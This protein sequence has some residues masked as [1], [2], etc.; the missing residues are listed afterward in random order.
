MSIIGFN[1]SSEIE[2]CISFGFLNRK[3]FIGSDQ[4]WY[5]MF[6]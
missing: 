5:F 6:S 2:K 3:G 1:A 4:K